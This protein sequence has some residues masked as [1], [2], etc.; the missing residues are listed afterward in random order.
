MPVVQRHAA[1]GLEVLPDFAAGERG[2]RHRLR[3]RARLGLPDLGQRQRARLRQH[4]AA[5]Q[6]ADAALVGRH[7]MGGVAFH[8]LDVLV[9]FATG[10]P[11]VVAGHVVLQ[12]DERLAPAAHFPH[13]GDWRRLDVGRQFHPR[14][15][16]TSCAA[17]FRGDGIGRN[18]GIAGR[19]REPEHAARR[20]RDPPDRGRKIRGEGRDRFLPPERGA[21]LARQCSDRAVTAGHQQAVG[22]EPAPATAAPIAVT[23]FHAAHGMTAGNRL[24]RP[25]PIHLETQSAGAVRRQGTGAHV[26][27]AGTFDAGAG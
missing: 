26:D 20:A 5:D 16:R 3:K 22:P 19:G 17:E 4:R 24:D 10:E 6:S 15:G 23:E 7:A 27:H 13:R 2:E 9:A 25:S 11:Y 1:L 14:A 8:V 18:F 21:E 12:I